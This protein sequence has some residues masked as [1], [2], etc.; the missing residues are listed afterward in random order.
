[1]AAFDAFVARLP[2]T[3]TSLTQATYLGGSGIDQASA[4]AIHPTTGDVYVAGF[5]DSS[6][7]PGTAGGAQPANGGGFDA[8]VARLPSTLTALTQATYLGGSGDD[9]AFALAIHPTTGDV[10]V[11]GDT[12]STNFPGTA[13]GA[14]PTSG[15]WD[16]F[17]ARLNLVATPSKLVNISTRGRVE[18]GDDRMIG[19]LIIE[20]S[21]PKTVLFRGRGPSMGGAPFFVPGTLRI[22]SCGSS[23]ARLS[24]ARTTTGKMRR[25]VAPGL[26]CGTP[27]QIMATGLDPCQP[28]PGE[29][30]PPLGCNLESAILVTLQPGAYTMHLVGASGEIGVGLVE[31]FDVDSTATADLHNI[32]TRGV[33]LTGDDIMIGGFIVQGSAPKTVLVRGRGPSMGGAPFFVPGVLADPFLRIFSGPTAIAQNNNWQDAPNCSPGFTCGTP[34]Q[35]TA[36]GL[37]PCVPNPGQPTPPPNC[38]LESAI[39]ITL[40]PGP[41]T[42]QLSGAFGETGIGLVEVFGI[43]F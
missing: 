4:L 41:Y 9:E 5:T 13:G 3:L 22:H 27:A 8:F 21:T 33:V 28:N 31:A 36:T 42:V 14:Q 2:S 40:P 29:G 26:P 1:M 32:S 18:T 24:S 10:Y 19:G 20:G 16:A 23:R 11:A 7:F 15:G 6:N 30:M 35:I 34:G 37:D 38:S 39:L 17:V 43:P 12:A 25:A